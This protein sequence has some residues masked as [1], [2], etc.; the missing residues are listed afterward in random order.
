MATETSSAASS[1]GYAAALRRN[2]G[3]GAEQPADR[4]A[5]RDARG[6]AQ[7]ARPRASSIEADRPAHRVRG[8]QVRLL[9]AGLGHR[10]RDGQGRRR[11]LLPAGRREGLPARLRRDRE[12]LHRPRTATTSAS[13]PRSP[14]SP[15]SPTSTPSPC[16]PGTTRVARVFCDCYDTETGELLD[17]DPRQNLKQIAHE[18]EEELGSAVPDRHRARDDV[19]ARS[20]EDGAG[21]RGRHE[22]LLLPHPPVRGAPS[23]APRRGRVR[24]GA[25]PRHELRRPRGRARPAR[26][27]LPL[28]PPGAH[29]RQHHDLPPGL[30]GGRP[31]ARPAARASCP[32]RSRACRPT[33]TTT[34]SRS[35]TSDGNNVFHDPDGPAQLSEIGPPLPRRDA[36]PLPRR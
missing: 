28:R 13:A 5:A 23:G 30:R 31:Q 18:F 2:R 27:E 19:A 21:A 33:A 8:H 12:P 26:A 14:S 6:G 34:T 16:C 1:N 9:P 3:D 4:P 20:R 11:E 36:R 7:R 25:R 35:S 10:P 22:A 17:A 29:R 15:R 24:P 32:S